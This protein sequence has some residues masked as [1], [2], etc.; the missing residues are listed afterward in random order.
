MITF[1]LFL[2]WALVISGLAAPASPH[3]QVH[4]RREYIPD[5]WNEIQRLDGTTPL[6]VRIG[7]TQ[8]NLDHGHDLLMEMSDPNS[9]RYGQ[10]FSLSEMHDFFAPADTSVDAV[11]SW[12]ESAG[13]ASNR[14][15]QSANKQWIQ[16]DSDAEEMESL[17]HTEYYI[18]SQSDTG[19]SHVACQ[20]YH[21]PTSVRDHIDYITPG[22]AMREVAG[23]HQSSQKH[24]KRGFESKPPIIE[25]LPLQLEDLIA[26]SSGWCSL[27]VSPRCIQEMYNIPPG[28]SATKGNEL[29]II[30]F[31]GD[32][33]SEE[34]LD[35]FFAT[36]Y[37]QIP[38]GTYP[39]QKPVDGGEAPVPVLDAG[40]ESDLDLLMAYP[41]IW[42]QKLI[43]FQTDD[44]AYEK[45]YTFYGFLNTFLDAIDGSYCSEVSPWDPPYPDPRPGGYNGTLQCGVY[46]PPTVISISYIEDEEALPVAYLRRQCAEFMKLGTMGVSVLVASGDF[47]VG[48]CRGPNHNAFDPLWP[49]AC[50]YLTAVGMTEIPFGVSH[51]DHKEQAAT[52]LA[53]GGGFSNVFKALDYQTQA[54]A[55]YFSRANLSYPYYETVDSISI[56]ANGGIYNRIGR[57]YPDVAAVG[58]RMLVYHQ[59]VPKGMGGS[60]A[61][62]PIFA[63]IL[64]RIN[65]ERL[66]VGKSTVGFV[67]PVLYAHPEAFFD[68]TVGDNP[69]C[70]NMSFPTAVGWDPVTGMGTPN[71]P[72]L[73]EVFMST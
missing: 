26:N 66:A 3:Y 55:D 29:G 50:P 30:E 41:I 22:I 62:T 12:L 18:Y 59:G 13:I 16:F 20:E 73:L 51:K 17:L 33:Y 68:V 21:V 54:V 24:V 25:P 32:V 35:M 47:G 11:R 15:S 49:A 1:Y 67:N 52:R 64:T 70:L 61:S 69:G 43:V 7:L 19:R 57:G 27:S 46:E 37:P 48:G 40:P 65:E 44:M 5:S 53:S 60:S 71:Y 31:M 39:I 36:F 45:N 9:N 8:S 72:A 63:A 2:L 38:T 28:H 34:D 56:G 58:E 23:V 10:H 14:I 42:P 6:P 4:E